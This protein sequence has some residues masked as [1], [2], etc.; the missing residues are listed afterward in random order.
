MHEPLHPATWKRAS[1]YSNGIMARGRMIFTG[2][3]VG[4]DA[5]QVFQTDDFSGQV[6]QVLENIVAV[7]AEGGAG[8]EHL[9]RLT[10]YVTDKHEY[11]GALRE[12][13]AA[14]R[15][16]IG[17]HYPAMALVQVV[18]LVEDRAKVEIEATAVVP[19]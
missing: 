9:V 12:V 4:W 18:A 2:G 14:Y 3:L 16:V 19:E 10:W 1:G 7:L 8:P 15:D 6:R 11:L 13:G 5:D 17:R